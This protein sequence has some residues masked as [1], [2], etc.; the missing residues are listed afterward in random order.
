MLSEVGTVL[1]T[2]YRKAHQ[3]RANQLRRKFSGVMIDQTGDTLF[4]VFHSVM[5]ACAFEVGWFDNPGNDSIK[6]RIGIH[7]GKV[8]ADGRTL[9]G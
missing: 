3:D 1:F 4:I 7:F 8:S 6:V 9:A 2:D 5:K